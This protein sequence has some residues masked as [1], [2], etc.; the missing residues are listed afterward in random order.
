VARVSVAEAAASS[1][2]QSRAQ[3]PLSGD[4]VTLQYNAA[5]KGASDR[6]SYPALLTVRVQATAHDQASFPVAAESP[7]FA[8]LKARISDLAAGHGVLAAAAAS[9]N[10]W[11]F[12]VYVDASS[13]DWAESF[14][15][16]IRSAM[17]DHLVGF[18]VA[19][20]TKW[21][22]FSRLS[23]RSA[24]PVVGSIVVF[25]VLPL[26]GMI[27][28]GS[29][30][31]P[32]AW[33]IGGAASMLAWVVP[34]AVFRKKLLAAQLAHPAVAFAA[35]SYLLA[36]VF[37]PVVVIISHGA[38]VAITLGISVL[39]GVALIGA[40]WPAQQRFYAR[41]R[42]R[43]QLTPPSATPPTATQASAD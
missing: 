39:L 42:T 43:G 26:I 11:I 5:L 40:L 1:R 9:S 41:M 2:W 27:P 19:R 31:P 23:P 38:R 29:Y 4:V 3:F 16:E 7:R 14:Q 12:L 33:A 37:F 25:V 35:F 30:K 21:A 36:T 10:G 34:L 22:T 8:E 28:A 6:R 20:D 13:T 24:N 17:A 32:W 18:S 15:A